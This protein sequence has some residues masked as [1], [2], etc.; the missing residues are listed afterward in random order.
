MAIITL[1]SDLGTTDY[2][3]AAVKGAILSQNQDVQII[4]LSHDIPKYDLIKTAFIV[5]NAWKHFPKG[6]IHI[7]GVESLESEDAALVAISAGGHYF[8]GADNGVFS[9]ILNVVVDE[10]V[11]LRLGKD[12]PTP[13]FPM[14]DVFAPAACHI[15][16]GGTLEVIG[17][18]RET[19]RQMLMQSPPIGSGHIKANI[20]YIDSFGNLI[21]NL[22]REMF[23]EAGRGEPFEIQLKSKDVITKITKNY[24]DQGP[25]SLIALFGHSGYLEIALVRGSA[26]KLLGLKVSD[27]IRVEFDAG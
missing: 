8:V 2:Y 23:E 15:A 6:T 3:L 12:A 17:R 5:S 20:I 4:D 7:I 11:Q 18:K 1:T 26:A 22:T 10:I 24:I 9:L 16:R 13:T 14:L 21:T 25:S 19:L 27:T